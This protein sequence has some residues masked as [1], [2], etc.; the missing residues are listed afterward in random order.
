MLSIP[1]L[2]EIIATLSS[3]HG[4]HSHPHPRE[5]T[6]SR[7]EGDEKVGVSML[8]TLCSM[9]GHVFHGRVSRV[10]FSPACRKASH[11]GKG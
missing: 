6:G 2:P 3:S 1:F 4:L 11:C 9:G 8:K 7:K 5:K 10:R